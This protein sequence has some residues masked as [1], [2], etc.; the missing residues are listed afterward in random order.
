MN[1]LSIRAKF[2][3]LV[4]SISVIF[5]V[6]LLAIRATSVRITAN[7]ERFYEDNFAVSLLVERIK[8]AQVDIVVDVRGL[9]IAYLLNLS[10]QI[11]GYLTNME[12]NYRETPELLR[13][14][15]ERYVGEPAS[16]QRLNSLVTDYQ[17][18]TKAFVAAMESSPNNQAPFPVF[19][20]FIT[21]Y[22]DLLA[23]FDD[24][25]AETDLA[26]IEAQN[27]A[28]D[29]VAAANLVFYLSLLIAVVAATVLSVF[30]SR[31]IIQNIKKVRDLANALVE[32]DLTRRSQVAGSDEVAELSRSLDETVTHLSSVIREIAQSAEVVGTNS[33]TVLDAN[34][35][36]QSMANQVTDNTSQVVTAIEE[37]SATS[38]NIAENTNNTAAASSEMAGMA[39]QGLDASAATI[40]TVQQMVAS[41]QETSTVIDRLQEETANIERIL[42]VI[43]GI[44]EQTNLL[45][46]NAAIE[47][48]RAGEQGRGFAV[49]ADEVRGLAQRS[50][51][52]VNEIETLLA[53]LSAA[54]RDAVTRMNAST[55][56]ADVTRGKIDENFKM[57]KD[58][59]ARV[60]HVN[61]QAQQIATAAEEQSA[62]AADISQNMHAV[63][64]LTNETAETATNTNTYSEEMNQVSSTVLSQ[65]KFFR[66]N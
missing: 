46:L 5:I 43:R 27:D 51:D 28:R 2:L 54:G 3:V 55:G 49:V 65:L 42:D 37:M 63:Q 59:L 39:T 11:P 6:A 66:I 62:V 25:K 18:K 47:A 29:A 31:N 30:I 58:I 57:L 1:N 36:I 33:E 16:L 60:E 13:A 10:D 15:N 19:S 23:H 48:A 64:Q 26:A 44:S 50:Q 45:A 20:A 7:F 12:R 52:S 21:S 40:D 41:L 4:I 56:M 32:G 17:T 34:R 14:L 61:E 24:L 38:K 53:Q 8:E 35:H 9:Q 22:N